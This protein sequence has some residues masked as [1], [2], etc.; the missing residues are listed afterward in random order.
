MDAGM[1]YPVGHLCAAAHEESDVKCGEGSLN[2]CIVEKTSVQ[3]SWL[4]CPPHL[5]KKRRAISHHGNCRSWHLERSGSF[6][7]RTVAAAL[8]EGIAPRPN[9]LL[10]DVL[11]VLAYRHWPV[12]SLFTRK[13]C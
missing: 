7:N 10:F 12:S 3:Y 5:L 1:P 13:L 6:S 9:P 8:S 2:R 11:A 4:R